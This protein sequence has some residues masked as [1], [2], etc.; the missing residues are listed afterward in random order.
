MF[1]C[2]T[3]SATKR[4]LEFSLPVFGKHTVAIF[5]DWV[6]QELK[7]TIGQREAF[8]ECIV[9]AGGFEVEPLPS[10]GLSRMFLLTRVEA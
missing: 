3:C 8:Q 5:D 7:N 2:D 6:G 1:D 9:D 10:Y 4:A